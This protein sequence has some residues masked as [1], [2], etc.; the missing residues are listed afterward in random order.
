MIVLNNFMHSLKRAGYMTNL[1]SG[2]AFSWPAPPLQDVGWGIAR[3]L[4]SLMLSLLA[5]MVNSAVTALLVRTVLTAGELIVRIVSQ[6]GVGGLRC[7]VAHCAAV[8]LFHTGVIV[9]YP[10]LWC[11]RATGSL[12]V[13]PSLMLQAY[14][15]C[16]RQCRVWSS[17][18][19]SPFSSA[20]W[21][22]PPLEHINAEHGWC[23]CSIGVQVGPALGGT[24]CSG[25]ACCSVPHVPA[26]S[27]GVAVHDVRGQPTHVGLHFLLQEQARRA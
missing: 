12:N 14:P 8:R 7:S 21:P 9:F 3:G 27:V 6:A 22:P 5:F 17:I 11:F 26:V 20:A 24:T 23:F 16:V 2:E 4:F 13:H 10:I 1:G 19:C 25:Q 15:W 18:V